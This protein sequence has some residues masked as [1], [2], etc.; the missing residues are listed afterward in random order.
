MDNLEEFKKRLIA[1]EEEKEAQQQMFVM[2]Q[3]YLKK[4]QATLEEEINSQ[5][6]MFVMA[7]G[8][9]KDLKSD[10]ENSKGQLE[11]ANK[12]LMDSIN[13]SVRI[14]RALFQTE[15]FTQ[16]VFPKS[17]LFFK[18][19]DLL[20]G[21]L[22]WFFEKNGK[23]Y[24]TAVDCTGH[25]VAGALLSMLIISLLRRATVEQSFDSPAEIITFIGAEFYRYTA[26]D[27][28]QTGL[29]DS[30]DVAML[31]VDIHNRKLRYCG[32]NRPLVMVAD[33]E[34]KVIKGTR[35]PVGLYKNIDLNV[36]QVELSYTPSTTAY[37]F[38]DG[39]TDQFGG[40]QGSKL[41]LKRLTQILEDIDKL[42]IF[43]RKVALEQFFAQWIKGQKQ[44]DD[45]LLLA[46]QL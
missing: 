45:I 35:I 5:R 21:D 9:L 10:L 46:I 27:L 37:I 2:T 12:Q 3:Q 20:S 42:P 33:G 41:T 22:Y 26:S 39:I 28:T 4:V 19:R 25:G 31:E 30:F 15:S 16:N 44:I 36:E 6:Q 13:Y 18:P 24:A 29:Y 7:Q 8:Y 11:K 40:E 34:S 38:S 1:L 23:K 43:E 32:V 17:F 14:Q